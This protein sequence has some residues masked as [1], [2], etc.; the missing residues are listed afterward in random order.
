MKRNRL[1]FIIAL[2]VL[3]LITAYSFSKYVIQITELH[4][5]TPKEFYFKSNILTTD[6]KTYEV[7]GWDG[8]SQYSISLNLQNYEDE[9][10][11]TSDDLKYDFSA[12]SKTDGINV[13]TLGETSG[14]LIGNSKEQKQID[15]KINPSKVIATGEYAEIELSAKSS[16]PYEK[17]IKATFK[18]YSQKL[19]VYDVDLK[20][21]NDEDYAKLYISTQ[22]LKEPLNITYDNTKVILD[23]NSD[24]LQNI[25]I[26][27]SGNKNKISLTLEKNSNYSI[28]FIKKDSSYNL[29]LNTDII[30]SK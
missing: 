5:Q 17:E 25:A 26:T 3:C 21:S 2:I 9:L 15:I 6:N 1:I 4:I 28:G 27:T 18:I 23:T 11:I 22:N 14:T 10:R 7:H 16:S 30:I 24:I 12:I 13:T 19:S 8:K 20:D 29:T